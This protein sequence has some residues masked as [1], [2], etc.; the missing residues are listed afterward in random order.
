M[1]DIKRSIEGLTSEIRRMGLEINPA[2][3][4]LLINGDVKEEENVTVIKLNWDKLGWDEAPPDFHPKF[5]VCG[6]RVKEE[7][8]VLGKLRGCKMK[9]E[10]K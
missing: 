3:C 1:Y 7:Y 9:I 6:K 8:K 4:C 2:R 10:S 5:Q